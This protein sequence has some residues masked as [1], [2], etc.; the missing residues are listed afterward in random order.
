MIWPA[1]PH[2]PT[3][4]ER[5]EGGIERGEPGLDI[6]LPGEQLLVQLLGSVPMAFRQIGSFADV[7]T[8]MVEFEATLF[9]VPN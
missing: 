9:K 3:G 8:K 5:I 6:T 7:I 4:S 2:S 1:L